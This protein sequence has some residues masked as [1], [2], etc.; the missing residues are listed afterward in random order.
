MS[1]LPP[2]FSICSADATVRALLGVNPTR[3]FPFGEAPQNIQKP[4]AVWQMVS[5][6]PENFLNQRPDIDS[7]SVQVDVYDLS[8]E[9]ARS[10]A[11]ALRDALE[12]NAHITR[13]GLQGRDTETRNYRVSFD[14][15]FW[16][17]RD[18]N[19]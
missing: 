14:A 4:Y 7:Y 2:V 12:D 3:L 18:A 16:T 1:L 6:S 5:G 17:P 15:T 9:G 8:A 19:S 13:W 10:V 11:A